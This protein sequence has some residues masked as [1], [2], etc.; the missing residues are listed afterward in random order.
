MLQYH[1]TGQTLVPTETNINERVILTANTGMVLI[2][3]AN[4]NTDG[5]GTLGTIITGASAPATGTLIKTITVKG[6]ATDSKGMVR[7]FITDS[8]G[9]SILIDEIE[10]PSITQAT[11][12]P[13]FEISYELDFFLQ[14]GVSLKASTQKGDDF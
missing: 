9:N 14:S 1:L 11:I 12:S 13:A 6:I 2:D 3:T 5:T 10:I 4:S 8:L 7:L